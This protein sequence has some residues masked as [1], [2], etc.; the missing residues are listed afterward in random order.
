MVWQTLGGNAYKSER[1]E[2]GDHRER[3]GGVDGSRA[4][5]LDAVWA[6]SG[7][8]EIRG[9]QVRVQR[10]EGGHEDRERNQVCVA[11]SHGRKLVPTGARE[12][13]RESRSDRMIRVT[14][15]LLSRVLEGLPS[16]CQGM[17]V[18]VKDSSAALAG[19]ASHDG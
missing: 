11:Q 5:D 8:T 13:A 19:A 15:L 12:Y 10:H 3:R 18:M 16:L 4:V 7:A 2:R 9:T 6:P 17:P 1:G 14:S